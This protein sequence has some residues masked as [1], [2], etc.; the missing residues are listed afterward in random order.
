MRR[1]TRHVLRASLRSEAGPVPVSVTLPLVIVL[2]PDGRL[3]SSQWR[4]VLWGYSAV[5]A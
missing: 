2:V 4:P 3:R 1:H 5:A